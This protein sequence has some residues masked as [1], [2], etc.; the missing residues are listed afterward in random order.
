MLRTSL[1]LAIPCVL[2]P[3]AGGATFTV[4][5]D[6]AFPTIQSGVDAAG[7]GDK[8]VVTKGTYRE[9]VSIPPGKDGL[10]I[11]AKGE[12]VVDARGP[13]GAGAGP[14]V[15]VDSADVT[16]VGLRVQNAAADGVA[17]TPGAGVFG[18][19]PGLVVK[20]CEFVGNVSHVDVTGDGVTILGSRFGYCDFEAVRINGA[21]ARV[22]KC[23]GRGTR[24]FARINGPDAVVEQ[25]TASFTTKS[26]VLIDGDR[27]RVSSCEADGAELRGVDIEGDDAQV[28][29]STIRGAAEGI[30]VVGDGATVRANV[31]EACIDG[32]VEVTGDAAWIEK[33]ILSGGAQGIRVTGADALVS[34]NELSLVGGYAI[35]VVGENP[36]IAKNQ[37]RDCV[38]GYAAIHVE[39]ATAGLVEKNRVEDGWGYGVDLGPGTSGFVVRKNRVIGSSD[40]F[41]GY[42]VGGSGHLLE[43]NVAEDTSNDGFHVVG[44]DHV[45]RGNVATDN[46]RDGFD[47]NGTGHS[48]EDNVATGNRAEGFENSGT[49][50]LVGNVAKKN[51]IDFA[52]DGTLTTFT[53]NQAGDGTDTVE[54]VASPEID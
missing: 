10:T 18:I 28:L 41:H 52:N 54:T 48:L 22:A 31:V 23:E 14:A 30:V 19:Q 21:N 42:E 38:G 36:T 37:V 17:M 7:P 39:S 51:R 4:K 1:L 6:G 53:G 25:C 3:A 45:L 9:N 24:T 12:V 44:A 35:D 13:A 2:S 40:A 27:A 11:S 20:D 47:C 34:K 26:F 32:D 33:N 16:L 46:A 50:A 29:D 49:A 43:D 8:V 15:T 5:P